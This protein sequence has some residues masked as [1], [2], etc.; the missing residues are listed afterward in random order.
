MNKSKLIDKIRQFFLDNEVQ[1]EY[2]L[3]KELGRNFETST[4]AEEGTIE[5]M[6]IGRNDFTYVPAGELDE[7]E[8]EF[9]VLSE[10]DLN[11]ILNALD[12]YKTEQD[13]T[14]KRASN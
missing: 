5:I 2:I 13:K 4:G 10:S 3:L 9:E 1:D 11:E 14:H 8:G 6:A 12:D 7:I